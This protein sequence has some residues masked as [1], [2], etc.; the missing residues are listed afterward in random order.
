[1]GTQKSESERNKKIVVPCQACFRVLFRCLI[2]LT[3]QIGSF[4]T[5]QE[6]MSWIYECYVNIA[7]LSNTYQRIQNL[8]MTLWVASMLVSGH[9]ISQRKYTHANLKL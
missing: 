8:F 1:M 5:F 2:W 7:T 6:Y 4:L 3:G 9:Y